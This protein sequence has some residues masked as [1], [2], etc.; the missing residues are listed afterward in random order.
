MKSFYKDIILQ[1]D[2]VYAPAED[3]Y[4]LAEIIEKLEL[5][6]KRVLDMGTG[7]G[8]LAIV[9]AKAGAS[10]TSTD[11]SEQAI[12]TAKQNA[13]QN[14][15]RI[16]FIHSDLLQNVSGTFDLIIFN[17]PY[18]PEDEYDKNIDT[19]GGI[20]IVRRFIEQAGRYLNSNG[21]ILL[22][23]SS[24]TGKQETF[25]I[26]AKNGFAAKKIAEKKIEWEKLFVF[27]VTK[28]GK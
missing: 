1:T 13:K 7:S 5:K 25:E 21:N 2:N 4:M 19:T 24:L 14:S 12:K 16:N 17:P 15:V 23:I 11:L 10:V 6:N 22:L 27:E 3:S 9:A 8:L 20:A 26:F 18:L 28:G